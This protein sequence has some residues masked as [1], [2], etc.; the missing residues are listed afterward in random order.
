MIQLVSLLSALLLLSTGWPI[1]QFWRASRPTAL[2]STCGWTMAAFAGLLGVA[3][4]SIAE[5][6]P[7]AWFGLGLARLLAAGLMLTPLVAV[8]G[9]R[10]PG[11]AAWNLVVVTLLIVFALPVLEQ[12]LLGKKLESDRFGLD[13]PRFVFFAI[14]AATGVVNYLPTRFGAAAALFASALAAQAI[15]VGP[16]T[17]DARSV[18]FVSSLAGLLASASAWTAL[19][20]GPKR[21]PAGIESAWHRLR[22]GW[23]LVWAVR[24]RDRWNDAASHYGSPLRLGWSDLERVAVPPDTTEA[25]GGSTDET[26]ST[27]AAEAQFRFLIERFVQPDAWLGPAADPT[28][29]K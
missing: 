28:R 14:V 7:G 13:A 20:L 24:F 21:E 23:G 11:A 1:W 26:D 10:W 25:V 9:A 17:I 5:P 12:W 27:A 29:E 16:W 22:D 4:L 15:S 2:R 19:L 8:L 6:R 18:V 3:V